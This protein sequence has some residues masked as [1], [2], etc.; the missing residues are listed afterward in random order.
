MYV[1]CK[2]H[3]GQDPGGD[4]QMQTLL[5]SMYVKSCP[6]NVFLLQRLFYKS[7]ELNYLEKLISK[8]EKY[9]NTL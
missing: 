5:R 9:A 7:G 4:L 2:G 1:L 8:T 3:M 6:I